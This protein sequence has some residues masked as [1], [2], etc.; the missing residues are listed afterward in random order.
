MH[1]LPL[2]IKDFRVFTLKHHTTEGK[3]KH[4]LTF[5]MKQ[6]YNGILRSEG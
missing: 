3:Y 5:V 4:K 2:S 1:L 6:L